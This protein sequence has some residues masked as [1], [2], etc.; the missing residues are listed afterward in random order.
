MPGGAGE[1]QEEG[2]PEG[3]GVIA[4]MKGIQRACQKM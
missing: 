1:E 2:G 4:L 3:K